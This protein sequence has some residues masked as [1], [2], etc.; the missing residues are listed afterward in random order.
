MSQTRP[1]VLITGAARRVGAVIARSLH[2][3]GYDLAL[4]CRSSRAALDALM[5]ELDGRRAGSTLALQADLA[6]A[7][8]LPG[9]IDCAAA[10]FGRLDALVNNASIFH[11]TPV[12][13]ITA[14]QCDAFFAINA[15]APLLLAQAA[16]PHLKTTRGSIVNITDIYAERP[17]PQHAAYGLSKAALRM[18]T[19]ALAQELGPEVRVN[20]VAPG[21][22]LWSE[23]PI[24]A[25]TM[26]TL[27]EQT[28]LQ[29]QGTPEDIAGA[30]LW[31]IRDA[32]Y[33]TGQTIRVDGGRILGA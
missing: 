31:L 12:G 3:A 24:K 6:D 14:A 1:V 16:A 11:A 26:Q 32:A 18:A 30:V 8:R 2:A 9:L 33:V 7:E 23:N 5:A 22:V 20:A 15:R 29:R 10:R 17:L 25:E 21:N 13:G 28:A 4:H 19:L 27:I